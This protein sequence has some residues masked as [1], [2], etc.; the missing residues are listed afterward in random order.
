MQSESMI[1]LLAV[2]AAALLRPCSSWAD[3][4]PVFNQIMC[5]PGVTNEAALERIELQ[6]QMCVDMNLSGWRR[7]ASRSEPRRGQ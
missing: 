3:S 2:S 7:W 1:G 5:H 4:V 6:N